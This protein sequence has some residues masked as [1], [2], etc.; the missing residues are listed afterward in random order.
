MTVN[1]K[2]VNPTPVELDF[3]RS[4]IVTGLTLARIAHDANRQDRRTRNS[5]N[6]RKAYDAVVHFMPRVNLNPE[7]TNEMKTKLEHLKSEL[8]KLGEEF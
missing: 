1:T 8:E 7:E 3:L 2:I 4:E 6:A 5:I